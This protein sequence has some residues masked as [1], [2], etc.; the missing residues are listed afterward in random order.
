MVIG[1]LWRQSRGITQKN[2]TENLNSHKINKEGMK[3]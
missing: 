2:Q 3:S 1:V